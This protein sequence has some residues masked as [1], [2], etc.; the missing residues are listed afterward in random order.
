MNS[1]AAATTGENQANDAA[2]NESLRAWIAIIL[3]VL[4]VCSTAA[5]FTAGHAFRVGYLYELGFDL[6]QL[7]EDF[8]ETAFWGFSG[9]LPLALVWF[10]ATVILLLACGLLLWLADALWR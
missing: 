10:A 4:F 3:S 6:A 5:L 2:K 7:P 9:G 1:E 8:H